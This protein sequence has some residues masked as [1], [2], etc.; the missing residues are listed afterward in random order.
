L[1][2]LPYS[3]SILKESGVRNYH[4]DSIPPS[5]H[6]QNQLTHFNATWWELHAI[7]GRPNTVIFNFIHVVVTKAPGLLEWDLHLIYGPELVLI[8]VNYSAFVKT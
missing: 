2:L 4:G 5:F 3:S 7:G 1:S 6:L 8:F